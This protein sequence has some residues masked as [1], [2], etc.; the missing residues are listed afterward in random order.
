[1]TD[2]LVTSVFV[3]LLHVRLD[4]GTVLLTAQCPAQGR[5]DASVGVKVRQHVLV[6]GEV[7]KLDQEP[8]GLEL[9]ARAP[10]A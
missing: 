10:L 2:V 1:V 4:P 9:R 5:H 3:R 8:L 7:E 6:L